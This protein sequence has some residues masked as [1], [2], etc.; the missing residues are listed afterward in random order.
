[1]HS[2][3]YRLKSEHKKI[4]QSQG[5]E[6]AGRSMGGNHTRGVTWISRKNNSL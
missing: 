2:E 3:N 1:V 4:I 6:G 5:V